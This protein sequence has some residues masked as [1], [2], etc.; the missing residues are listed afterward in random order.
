MNQKSDIPYRII[1]LFIALSILPALLFSGHDLKNTE[2]DHAGSFSE[3]MLSAEYDINQYPAA[4]ITE[5][6]FRDHTAGISQNHP[7]KRS[8]R[9]DTLQFCLIGM[10]SLDAFISRDISGKRNKNFDNK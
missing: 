8:G 6:L 3:S 1:A 2:K 7:Q 4:F 10:V 9:S 5:E